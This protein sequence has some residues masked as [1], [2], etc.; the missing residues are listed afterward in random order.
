MQLLSVVKANGK[1]VYGWKHNL[2]L[3]LF[4]LENFSIVYRQMCYLYFK[5]MRVF[6]LIFRIEVKFRTET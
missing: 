1:K 2:L 4:S 3:K 6:C 5:F